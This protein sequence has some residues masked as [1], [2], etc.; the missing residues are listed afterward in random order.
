MNKYIQQGMSKD[1]ASKKAYKEIVKEE[2]EIDEGIKF[3]ANK[4]SKLA[5]I[6]KMIAKM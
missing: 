1:E 5:Y 3:D 4:M 2:V 6:D